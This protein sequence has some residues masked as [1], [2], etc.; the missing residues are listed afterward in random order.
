M[1]VLKVTRGPADRDPMFPGPRWYDGADVSLVAPDP[2]SVDPALPAPAITLSLPPL[3]PAEDP[4]WKHA[5]ALAGDV[6]AVLRAEGEIDTAR[7]WCV[8]AAMPAAEISI[9][10]IVAAYRKEARRG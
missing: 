8:V 10:A 4:K 6:L 5:V 3:P 2:V 1:R 9:D 7:L